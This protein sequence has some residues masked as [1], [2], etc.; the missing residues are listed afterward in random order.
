MKVYWSSSAKRNF[1]NIIDYLFLEWS[2]NEVEKFEKDV[3]D[4]ILRLVENPLICPESMIFE[5]RKCLIGKINSLIY[6]VENELIYIVAIIDN[7][8][9]HI[10]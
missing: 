1:K 8:S 4:L 5:L 3:S 10:Y 7:R 2:I 6:H 9:S